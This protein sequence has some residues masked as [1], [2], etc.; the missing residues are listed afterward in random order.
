MQHQPQ[1][2]PEAPLCMV[3]LVDAVKITLFNDTVAGFLNELLEATVMQHQP[4][5]PPGGLEF[6]VHVSD[7]PKLRLDAYPPG[8]AP[9][10]L[11]YSKVWRCGGVDSTWGAA[12]AL[13]CE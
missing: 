6:A 3:L 4:Q 5:A 1:P 12:R 8:L 10:V 9:L 2:L 13:G 11:G 7:R